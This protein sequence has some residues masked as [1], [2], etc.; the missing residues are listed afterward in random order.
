MTSKKEVEDIIEALR[1]EGWRVEDRTKAWMVRHPTETDPVAYPAI[2]IHRTPSGSRTWRNV[3]SA[4]RRQ[5]FV[6]PKTS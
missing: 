3:L 4:L 1:T 5:G 6:W 2:F